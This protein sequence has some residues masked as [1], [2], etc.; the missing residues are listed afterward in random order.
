MR[1]ASI[2]GGAQSCQADRDKGKEEEY[3]R[4]RQLSSMQEAALAEPM[5]ATTGTNFTHIN[6]EHTAC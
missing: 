6:S 2:A 5:L 1:C 4:T 3:T